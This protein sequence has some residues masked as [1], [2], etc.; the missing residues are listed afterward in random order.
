MEER[1]DEGRKEV[2]KVKSYWTTVLDDKHTHTARYIYMRTKD[3][4]CNSRPGEYM[5]TEG[6]NKNSLLK[7][8]RKQLK[9]CNPKSLEIPLVNQK[10]SI[11]RLF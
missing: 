1:R 2:T 9:Q 6:R 8:G 7:Q 10:T 4:L 11:F 5:Q 3:K